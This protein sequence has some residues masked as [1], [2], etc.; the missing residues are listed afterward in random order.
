M[1]K[2]GFYYVSKL[3]LITNSCVVVLKILPYK[4]R[5]LLFECI[6]SF[7]TLLGVYFRYIFFKSI[8]KG[9]GENIY[10]GK[11]VTFKNINKLVVGSNV[12]FHN[13]CYLDA[14]GEVS[15]GDNVSIAHS[16]S[17]IS[18]D[19]TFSDPTVPIKYQ[20]IRVGEII[21]ENNVWIG[22]GVRILSNSF[23]ESDTVVAA[24]AV[25]NKRIGKGLYA[26]LPAKKIRDIL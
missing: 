3:R 9:S 13:Y 7:P 16:S 14:L 15:I 8:V 10:I 20:P 21:I 22:C 4:V 19:H 5:L 12:S 2:S 24:N 11:W 17:I 18:F 25:V 23:I 1:N 26:G 6:T